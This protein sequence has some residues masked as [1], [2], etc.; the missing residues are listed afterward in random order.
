MEEPPAG[1]A[2]KRTSLCR[3]IEA[4]RLLWAVIAIVVSTAIGAIIGWESHGIIGALAL[5]FVGMVA[6]L[7][8]S[9]PSFVLQILR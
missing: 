8:L 3:I 6:G 7:F 5:A 9:S 1:E 4:I 2:R